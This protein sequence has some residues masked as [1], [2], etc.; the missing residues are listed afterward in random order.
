MPIN[1]L[2]HRKRGRPRKK[3]TPALREPSR[4]PSQTSDD[5]IGTIYGPNKAPC[6]GS[7]NSI[8]APLNANDLEL[9]HHY[10]TEVAC[11]LGDIS[12]WRDKVPCLAFS[13]HY[14]LHLLLAMSA[15]H[16]MRARPG[17]ISRFE[18]IAESHF[19]MGLLPAREEMVRLDRNNCSAV[20]IA[21]VL[22]CLC[23]FARKP[24]P[25]HLLVV[26]GG[27]EVSW[28][29]L[30]RG[31]RLVVENIGLEAVFS[32]VLGPW[33]PASSH[34]SMIAVDTEFLEFVEWEEALDGLS[35]LI[36]ST[37]QQHRHVYQG[38]F[39]TLVWCFEQTYGR[40]TDRRSDIKGEFQ[41]IVV[42]LYD[43]KDS[44]VEY[45]KMEEDAAL[46]ILAHFSVLLQ[47]L[48][49]TWYMKGWANHILDGV[50]QA[51]DAGHHHWLQWPREQIT[52]IGEMIDSISLADVAS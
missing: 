25:D 12:L 3:Y 47:T 21:A 41:I 52:N 5:N 27:S 31:V 19:T 36:Q 38:A 46:I 15:L 33:P 23:M 37:E 2:G 1:P 26:A 42:W 29:G 8:S 48:E 30:F 45:L 4:V 6:D 9:L 43:M 50:G 40:S 16:L 51:L 28:L 20:Y 34:D 32:G 39:K 14:V 18:Q 11:N 17:D 10:L 24:A 7:S 49:Y 22:V 44:F 13:N 35:D